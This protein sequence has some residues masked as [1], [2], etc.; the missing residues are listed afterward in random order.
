[1]SIDG[2]CQ[3]CPDRNVTDTFNC[4]MVCKKYIKFQKERKAYNKAQATASR[5]NYIDQ[6][7]IKKGR[8]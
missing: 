3:N 8:N 5:L 6:K 1:M 4:H 7:R 2:P